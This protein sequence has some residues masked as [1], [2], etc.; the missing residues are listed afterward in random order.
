MLSPT[1]GFTVLTDESKDQGDCSEVS[2]FICFVEFFENKPLERYF[3]IVKL[4][5]SKKTVSLQEIIMTH[6]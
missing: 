1:S 3:E 2:L 5:T 4:I 6:L